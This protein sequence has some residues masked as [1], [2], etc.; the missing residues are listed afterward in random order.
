METKISARVYEFNLKFNVE[1]IE[2][3]MKGTMLVAY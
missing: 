1:L 3:K 2:D